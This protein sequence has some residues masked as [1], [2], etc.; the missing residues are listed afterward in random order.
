MTLGKWPGER[1]KLGIPQ[2]GSAS[3]STTITQIHTDILVD[4]DCDQPR[5]GLSIF[6]TS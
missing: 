6:V 4:V 5:L 1:G 3:S 2:A